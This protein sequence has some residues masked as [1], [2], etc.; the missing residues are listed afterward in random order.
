[1]KKKLAM[2]LGFSVIVYAL[3]III[4]GP[5]RIFGA[6]W[7]ISL[8]SFAAAIL[9]ILSSLFFEFLRWLY[10]LRQLGIR[11]A[12]SSCL[13]IF[14]SGL[15]LGFMPAKSGELL[16]YYLLKRLKVPYHKTIPVH[17]VSNLTVLFVSLAFASPFLIHFAGW[18]VFY[19]SIV[20]FIL[21]FFSF[22]FPIIY[23]KII[24]FL[25][26]RIRLKVLSDLKKSLEHSK[27]L[28]GF[29]QLSVS[30]LLTFVYYGL[31]GVAFFA[32]SSNFEI[33]I[34]WYQAFG[35][36]SLSLIIGVLSMLPGGI[37]AVEGSGITLLMNYTD[38]TSAVVMM[39]MMRLI[40]LWFTILIGIFA[41]NFSIFQDNPYRQQSDSVS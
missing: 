35:I 3:I 40:T 21:L 22:R 19:A 24:S 11:V 16:R 31:I 28:L 38:Q 30:L 23:V 2:S 8:L 13:S 37:G 15:M 1:M 10:Y 20:F 26:K 7:K 39:M 14:L 32:V 33:S 41:A 17:F 34:P 25:Q 29:K 6:L 18:H 9:L 27:V 5:G 36:Y 12:W 4:F